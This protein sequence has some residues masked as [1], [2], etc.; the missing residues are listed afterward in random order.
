MKISAEKACSKEKTVIEIGILWLSL[1]YMKYT[2][3]EDKICVNEMYILE[4]F[5]A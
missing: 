1:S 5:Q 2:I 3:L 4:E